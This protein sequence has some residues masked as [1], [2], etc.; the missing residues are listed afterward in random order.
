[1]TTYALKE[2]DAQVQA[3]MRGEVSLVLRKGG[4]REIRKGFD[5]NHEAFWLYP[6]YLHQNAAE[7]RPPFA[8]A[9]RPDPDPGTVHFP[10]WA[11]VAG[12]WRIES[13]DRALALE[14]LQALSEKAITSRFN[15]RDK[16]WIHA[17][18]LRVYP[19]PSVPALP[20]TREMLGCVSW[21]PFEADLNTPPSLGAPAT[22]EERLKELKAQVDAAL[23]VASQEEREG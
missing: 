16:P 21:V 4:I 15:Y 5:V 22:P 10:A 3:L 8:A 20:E 23:N 2:W 17:L 13:L 7:L 1:M 12:V 14:P 6:T 18:L 11:E 19:Q 9:L